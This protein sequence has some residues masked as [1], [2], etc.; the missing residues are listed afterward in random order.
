MNDNISILK[1]L[2]LPET[3]VSVR[4]VQQTQDNLFIVTLDKLDRIIFCPE[5]G[6]RMHSK[7][8][9]PRKLNHPVL[10][11][12]YAGT[13]TLILRQRKWHCPSCG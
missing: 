3:E 13:V 7:G 10:N 2:N 5:C 4:S 1:F 12:P 8:I 6:T 11:G 9:Y